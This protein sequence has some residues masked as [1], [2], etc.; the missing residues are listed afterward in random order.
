MSLRSIL[1]YLGWPSLCGLLMGL[2]ILVLLR[3]Q[4]C[5]AQ[6]GTTP[7]LLRK[8]AV[9]QAAPAVVNIYAHKHLKQKRHPLFN[10][11][12]FR[13]FFNRSDLP[14][15]ERMQSSRG[16]GVIVSEH[17]YILTNNHVVDGG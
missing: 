8:K 17:G 7:G 12:L 11:P 14:Q 6:C 13:H 5:P 1:Q 16:S 3:A 4:S 9:H 10:D 15:Q 2:L